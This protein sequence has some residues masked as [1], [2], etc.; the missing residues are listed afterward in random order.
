MS[1]LVSYIET[2]G[3]VIMRE[4]NTGGP[5]EERRKH[6]RLDK[7]IKMRYQKMENISRKDPYLEGVLLDISSAGLRFLAP[8]PLEINSQLVIVLEFP[9][10]LTADNQWTPDDQA[11]M[12]VQQALGQVLRV[13]ASQTEPG[14][15]EVAVQLS[16]QLHEEDL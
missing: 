3:K 12:G 2:P 8:K 15:F 13:Q 7:V 11:E 9:G 4:E 5:Q 14:Q 6:P 1:P 10:W 16:G